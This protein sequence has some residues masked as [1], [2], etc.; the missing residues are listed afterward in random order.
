MPH[1]A[2]RLAGTILIV[3]ASCA[4]SPAQS[5]TAPVINW[6][7]H[8]ITAPALPPYA[9][10]LVHFQRTI[11]LPAK[12]DHFI[13]RVSADNAFLLHV[14]GETVGRGPAKGDLA[15]W[16]FETIDLAPFLHSGSNILAAIVWN[17][18]EYKSAAQFTNRTAFLLEGTSPET[19]SANTDKSWQTEIDHGMTIEP[20]TKPI[21][22]N[23][24]AA[25]PIEIINTKDFDAAWDAPITDP[26][27]WAPAVPLDRAA[28]RGARDADSNWQLVPDLLPPM[29]YT[30][31]PGGKVVR[32]TGLDSAANFP[33][34][35]ITIPA[36]TTASIL[37]D[38]GTLTTGYPELSL[39]GGNAATI[40]LTYA[41][42]LYDA[43]GEKGNRNDITGK[44]IA[45]IY[46]DYIA[47][48]SNNRTF[49]PFVW[50]TWRYLQIDIHT[51]DQPLQL[52][53]FHFTFSAFPFVHRAKFTSD[54][55]SLE[56]IWNIGWRTARLD[57]HDTYMDTPYWE[58]L[59][60]VGDTR[61]QA[62]I[63]YSNAGDDRLAR[64]AINAINDSRMPDGITLSR[65]P[66]S[67]FQSIPPFSLLWIG[68]V[69]DYALYR[70]DPAFVR[71]Q[72]EGTRTVLAWF[73]QHQNP[74]GLMGKLPW[75]S[76]IDWTE[77]FKGGE[78]PQDANGDSAIIT[79]HYIEALREAAELESAYGD[80]ILA[81]R[82]RETAAKSVSAIQTLCWN[83]QTHLYTDTPHGNHYS[84]HTNAMAVWLD[85][86][87]A[88]AQRGIM[89]HILDPANAATIS[90]ASYYYRFYLNRALQHAGMGDQYIQQLQPWRNMIDLGLTTWAE[91]P[92]PTRS[93]S[94]AWSAHPNFDLLNIVAGIQPASLGFKS[95][96]IAPHLGPLH[97]LTASYPHPQ[98]TIEV[99]YT[100]E[101]G[102]LHAIVHLPHNLHGTFR[103][104]N[105][106]YP[107]TQ[108]TLNLTIPD[109][110]DK[111]S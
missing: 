35:A 99:Q 82:Y 5:S 20:L 14:N 111:T 72:L 17:Y 63:S 96:L 76:F 29:E 91:Q 86:A 88:A 77:D 109:N 32:T 102:K 36:N 2:R 41:E 104:Q 73:L 39:S 84:Q 74:N 103:W 16:R 101:D 79:L 22:H 1:R 12:P 95:V 45:G 97:T 38:N 6:Q 75:W 92:E 24:Y 40:R 90:P 105:R 66:T 78:P 33:D 21:A 30:P 51:G 87:P 18:G 47:D 19:E 27:H 107:I 50:R 61:L 46:D 9:P 94:H 59:Q 42:A 81:Q 67:L 89:T 70:D 100:R 62:L 48:G 25:E 53:R 108:G 55:P 44:H 98:G 11:D 83:P 69:H 31:Q 43:K 3:I 65:Y 23:Y 26:S 58:R 10:A 68:M 52:N 110:K 28:S 37:I 13:V 4:A 93:D 80:P 34:G 7:A 15:H 60:Y 54:D 106:S 49:A 8:W 57:A 71:Q 64:Q 85:V 56:K